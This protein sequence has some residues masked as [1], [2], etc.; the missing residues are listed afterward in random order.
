[1]C[2]PLQ[3]IEALSK[4]SATAPDQERRLLILEGQGLDSR[5]GEL[6]RRLRI[7]V[8]DAEAAR[9]MAE[10]QVWSRSKAENKSFRIMTAWAS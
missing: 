5:V 1:M 4:A 9:K 3:K 2:C 7:T 6:E 8:T 10:A